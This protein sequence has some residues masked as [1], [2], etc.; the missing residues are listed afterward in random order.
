MRAALVVGDVTRLPFEDASFDKMILSEVLEHLPDDTAA[1]REARRVLKPGGVLAIT[2]PNAHYPFLWDPPN[3][4]RERLGLG[5][6]KSEPW[7]GIW[8]DHQRLYAPDRLGAVVTAAG[9]QPTDF[10]LETR[11]SFPF[12][13][14]VVYAIGKFLVERGLVK[15]GEHAKAK[16][17]SFWGQ[18]RPGVL[19]A[20]VRVFTAPDRYNR[21]QYEIWAG[22]EPVS[23]RGTSVLARVH[24]AKS[25]DSCIGSAF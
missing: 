1:L 9:L 23:T 13:H 16:R 2:V 24:P 6:F 17:W 5:H 7:S 21:P 3:Y 14:H 12:A 10:R 8:T 15:A 25:A 18:D 22:G 11:Y 4:V 19:G 20:A